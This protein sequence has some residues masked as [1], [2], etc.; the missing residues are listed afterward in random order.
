MKRGERSEASAAAYEQRQ[1]QMAAYQAAA[2]VSGPGQEGEQGEEEGVQVGGEGGGEDQAAFFKML[3][4]L[5]FKVVAPND[6]SG[7]VFLVPPDA[8]EGGE[9]D[10][11]MEMIAEGEEG[12]AD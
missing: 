7:K 8:Q 2:G 12:E 1:Q 10:E 3:Q 4:S 5:G 6:G 9:G 11:D